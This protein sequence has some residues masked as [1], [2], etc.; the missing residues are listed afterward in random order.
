MN[1]L[2]CRILAVLAV[3]FLAGCGPGGPKLYKA[4]G[5][6]TLNK[7][8]LEGAQVTFAYDDGNFASG[9]TDAAGKFSLTYM[10]NPAGARAGKC[11][12]SVSKKPGSTYKANSAI[13]DATPKSAEDLRA[14]ERAQKET[15]EQFTKEQEAA[16]RGLE[17]DVG[18]LEVTSDETKNDFPIDLKN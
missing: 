13:L 4:G 12:V 7:A 10:N 2:T 9:Y 16:G 14:K 3:A 6:V 8:P 18:T 17:K 15:M 1:K 11:K 5:T